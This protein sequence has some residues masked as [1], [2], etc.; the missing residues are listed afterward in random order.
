M[1]QLFG[2]EFIRLSVGMS[3]QNL[4]HMGWGL[5]GYELK[6]LL[7]DGE[8]KLEMLMYDAKEMTKSLMIVGLST[9]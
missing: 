8:F 3:E 7:F 4:L 6:L 5:R 9:N 2:P 1:A